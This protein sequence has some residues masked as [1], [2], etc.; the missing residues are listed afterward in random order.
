MNSFQGW[1]VP[2]LSLVY[3]TVDGDFGYQAMGRVPYRD[4]HYKGLKPGWD[5]GF[6]WKGVIP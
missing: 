1:N 6:G 3:G 5:P 4:N 2:T